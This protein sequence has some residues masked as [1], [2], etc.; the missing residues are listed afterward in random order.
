MLS[1]LLGVN[2]F[3]VCV[4]TSALYLTKG[5]THSPFQTR[6]FFQRKHEMRSR[7]AWLSGETI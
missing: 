6:D 7:Q 2:N 4:T 5:C 3:N 1:L